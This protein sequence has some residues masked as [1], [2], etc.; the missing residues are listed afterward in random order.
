MDSGLKTTGFLQLCLRRPVPILPKFILLL[1]CTRAA[2][3]STKLVNEPAV[4]TPSTPTMAVSLMC[5][6]TKQQPVGGG[7]C[8]KKDWTAR[9]ISTAVG[10]T[11]NEALGI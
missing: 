5:T 10:M 3:N 6:V 4:F 1:Q 9:L 8:F 11:I 7:L 2:L